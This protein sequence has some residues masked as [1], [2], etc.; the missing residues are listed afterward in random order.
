[1]QCGGWRCE[2]WMR[3]AGGR[4]AE[5]GAVFVDPRRAELSLASR[6]P[7]ICRNGSRIRH[8]PSSLPP[9]HL[10]LR[11]NQQRSSTPLQPPATPPPASALLTTAAARH[12]VAH[13]HVARPPLLPHVSPHCSPHILLRFHALLNVQS[14]NICSFVLVHLLV[15]SILPLLFLPLFLRLVPVAGGAAFIVAAAVLR[16]LL[17]SC[18]VRAVGRGTFPSSFDFLFLLLLSLVQPATEVSVGRLLSHFDD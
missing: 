5:L 2:R 10:S 17:L 11:H 13:L 9:S 8:P 15:L 4:S 3:G 1:M 18:T 7:A 16:L 12:V 14:S 6:S